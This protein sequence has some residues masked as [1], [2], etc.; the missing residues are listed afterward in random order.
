MQM[1]NAVAKMDMMVKNV[2]NVKFAMVDFLL[3]A[4]GVNLYYKQ[5]SIILSF[6]PEG[7]AV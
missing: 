1:E 7:Y 2:I 6:L 3:V 5:F 4:M